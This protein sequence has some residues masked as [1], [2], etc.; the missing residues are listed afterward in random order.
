MANVSKWATLLY[1]SHF[2]GSS[3]ILPHRQIKKGLVYPAYPR[4]FFSLRGLVHI[5]IPHTGTP[6]GRIIGNRSYWLSWVFPFVGLP[7]LSPIY[8]GWG[9]IWT[10]IPLLLSSRPTSWT[11]QPFLFVPLLYHTLRGLSRGF[12]WEVGIFLFSTFADSARPV[13]SLQL[14]VLSEEMATCHTPSGKYL[15]SSPLDNYSI[16][17]R[18]AFVKH[19]ITHSATFFL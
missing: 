2:C 4:H 10:H 3:T 15:I 1:L 11:T 12:F 8:G 19:F 7:Y 6:C 16:A 18:D 14:S 9:G 17:F 13:W 5:C